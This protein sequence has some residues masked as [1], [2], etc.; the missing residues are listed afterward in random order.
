MQFEFP[1][2][3]EKPY[4]ASKGKMTHSDKLKSDIP[5]GWRAVEL[6][7][8]V[9]WITNSQPPKSEFKYNEE[10]GYVRFIQNRDYNSESY[11]TYVKFKKSMNLVEK[12]DILMDK[13]GDAGRV[14]YGISGVFNVAL[15]QIKPKNSNMREYIRSLLLSKNMYNYLHN[16]CVASTRASLSED[17]LK[18][19]YILLPNDLIIHK[20][21]EIISP[22]RK[23]ILK[24]K[25]ENQKIM[26]L[27]DR[28]SLLL[29][30]NQLQ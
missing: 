13:Y 8:L 25:D 4:K 3:D 30:N 1:N 22:M 9:D 20:F 7:N 15:A 2:E 26:A 17:N 16:S 6:L 19:L 27:R 18:L 11:K 24:I 21:E 5:E 10:D 12:L 23:Q 28:L 14:R 29:I